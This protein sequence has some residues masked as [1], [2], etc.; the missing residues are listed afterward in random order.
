MIR[1]PA[2]LEKDAAGEISYIPESEPPVGLRS[3]YIGGVYE[4]L[5]D[6]EEF[7]DTDD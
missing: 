3:R 5:E 2:K 1:I 6:G 4:Y 7:P